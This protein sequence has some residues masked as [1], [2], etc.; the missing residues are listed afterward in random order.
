[1]TQDQRKE[2]LDALRR[3]EALQVNGDQLRTSHQAQT[4]GSPDD[5]MRVKAHNWG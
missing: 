5:T 3:G 1:M 4:S 2:L